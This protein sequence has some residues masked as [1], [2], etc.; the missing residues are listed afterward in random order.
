MVND[1]EYMDGWYDEGGIFGTL[2][3]DGMD[4]KPKTHF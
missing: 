1:G 4:E 3:Q 2:R